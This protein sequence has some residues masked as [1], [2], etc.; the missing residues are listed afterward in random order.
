MAVARAE[1]NLRAMEEPCLFFEPS[2]AP[3][4]TQGE[5]PSPP[6]TRATIKNKF[7]SKRAREKES[8]RIPSSAAKINLAEKQ[9]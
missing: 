1:V 6:S 4:A 9:G 5:A 2:P 7:K 8:L 3:H